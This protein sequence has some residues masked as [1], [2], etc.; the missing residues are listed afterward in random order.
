MGKKIYA[1]HEVG[2]FLPA[3]TKPNIVLILKPIEKQKVVY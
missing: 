2:F 1:K 3:L